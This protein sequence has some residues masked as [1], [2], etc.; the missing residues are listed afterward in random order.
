MHCKWLANQT[1]WLASYRMQRREEGGGVPPP[2]RLTCGKDQ[3]RVEWKYSFN[4]IECHCDIDC[5]SQRAIAYIA[6]FSFPIIISI[7]TNNED[8][9]VF[10]TRQSIVLLAPLT[11]ILPHTHFIIYA[12]QIIFCRLEC[13]WSI[14][15]QASPNFSPILVIFPQFLRISFDPLCHIEYHG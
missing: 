6:L 3:Q 5:P 11:L 2:P 7:W 1:C 4:I 15:V 13:F 8:N 14:P 10:A 12:M 9:S